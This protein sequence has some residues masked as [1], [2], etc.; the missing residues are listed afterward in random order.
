[1]RR[2]RTSNESRWSWGAV[3]PLRLLHP[4][5]ARKPLDRV[6][7]LGPFPWGGDANTVAQASV[8]P[9]DPSANP[10]FIQSLRMVVDLGHLESSRW[11]LPG[12]QSGNPLS[13]H[14]DDQLPLWLAGEGIPIAFTEAEVEKTRTRSLSLSPSPA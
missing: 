4:L 7:N 13:P 9:T 5:G 12:G 8:D 11:V 2:L 1:M 3:R 14:Y 6:F 10:G